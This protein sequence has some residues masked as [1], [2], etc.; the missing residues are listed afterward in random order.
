MS[1][2]NLLFGAILAFFAGIISASLNFNFYAALGVFILVISGIIF[3]LKLPLAWKAAPVFLAALIFGNFYYHFYINARNYGRNVA[4]GE[5][6]IFQGTIV[7]EPSKTEN[8]ESFSVKLKNPY[9]GKIKIFT[10][11]SGDW[12]YGD[13][14]E[15][16]GEV[17]EPQ[18]E[19]ALPV[20]F[21]PKTKIIS[22]DQGFWPKE[23]LLAFKARLLGKFAMLLPEE[24]SALLSGITF[25]SRSDFSKNFKERMALS[26]T[27]HLVALSGYNIAILVFAAAQIFGFFLSRRKTFYLTALTIFIFILM[28]GAEA[29]VVRAAI[30]GFLMLLAKETGRIYSLRNPLALTAALMAFADPTILVFNVGFQLSFFS[31]LGIVYLGPALKRL[32]RFRD[33]G[34]FGWRDNMIT[35]ASAQLAVMPIIIQVFGRFSLT[36]ILANIL[37]LEFIPLTMFFGFALAAI[38]SIYIYLGFFL[39][40]LVGLLLAYEIGVINLFSKLTL[41][42]PGMPANSWITTIAY[43]L[44]LI[45]FAVYYAAPKPDLSKKTT[46]EEN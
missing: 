4:F 1:R 15:M 2:S 36:A 39:A 45:I 10:A 16:D 34:I 24:E 6:I 35:T 20:S 27:T 19:T 44:I 41:P 28:V 31:L 18:S 12:R 37:I 40:K 26:G 29:S 32:F 11:L 23:K 3:F 21:F 9:S 43:Y 25:G 13:W 46:D 38:S 17:R 14:L 30:M 33:G 8:S 7:D 42:L 22:R 5:K